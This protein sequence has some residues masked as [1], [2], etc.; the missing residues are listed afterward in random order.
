VSA[1]YPDIEP[2]E[3]G[4]LAVGDSHELAWEVCGNPGGYPVVV[5]H[6][7]PGSGRSRTARRLFDPAHYRVILF[8]QRG[9]GA[10]TPHASE[11]G[12][13]LSVVTTETML[14]DIERLRARFEIDRWLVYG[15]SWGA[16]LAL[17]YAQRW[18]ARV[19]GLILSSVATTTRRE[20]DWIT[21]G[22]GA[23]LPEAWERFRRAVP[24]AGRDGD[25]PTAYHRL[26]M[27][28][29][30]SVTQRAAEAWCAWEQALVAID[31]GHVPHP[32]FADPRFRLAFAR[33]VTHVWSNRAW[34]HDGQILEDAGRLAGIPGALIHGRLDISGPL[35]TSWELARAW[36]DATLVPVATAGHDSRDPGMHEAIVAATDRFREIG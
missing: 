25:L 20:I 13:D 17:L 18:P 33:L 27:D 31:P 29:L 16:T 30:P 34:L 1:L 6:G 23:F 22:V 4:R 5:L 11:A 14:L 32:R 35:V 12:V 21:R 8:D 28:P 15:S 2:G 26:L 9:C 7:G 19:G 36:P 24:A 10:S 3:T